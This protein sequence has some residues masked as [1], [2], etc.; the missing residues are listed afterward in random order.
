MPLTR[1]QQQQS[2][3]R[4]GGAGA[5]AGGEVIELWRW[6]FAAL[7]FRFGSRDSVVAGVGIADGSRPKYDMAN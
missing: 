6:V 7:I 3:G 4:C 5:G 2:S 1:T